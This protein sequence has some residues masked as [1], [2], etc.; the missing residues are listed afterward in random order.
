MWVSNKQKFSKVT[1]RDT[2]TSIACKH[3]LKGHVSVA[4]L[5][6]ASVTGSGVASAQSVEEAAA[7]EGVDQIVVTGIRS[8]IRNALDTKRNAD[9]I[10][11]GISAEDIGK[12]PDQNVAE[13]LQRIP[14]VAIDR[15]GGEGR[16]VSIRGLGPSFAKTLINGREIATENPDRSFSFDTIASELVSAANVYKTQNAY[17]PEGGI[18]GTVDVITA[19]PFDYDGFTIAGSVEGQFEQNRGTVDPEMSFIVSNTFMDDKLGLLASFTRQERSTEFY[20]T[21]TESIVNASAGVFYNFPPFGDATPL[22]PRAVTGPYAYN[23]TCY[24]YTSDGLTDAWRNQDLTRSVT[25]E[26]RVRTGVSAAAQFRPFDDMVITADYIYSDFDVDTTRVG[27]SNW[28]WAVQD[29]E[30]LEI[31]ENGALVF[32]EHGGPFD[33]SGFSHQWQRQ[34]RPTN[35]QMAGIN[36]D[37]DVSDRLTVVLDGAWSSATRDNKGLD[38][39]GTLEILD[40]PGFFVEARGGVP[41]IIG[42]DPGSLASLDN[43]GALRARNNGDS[44][45][46]IDAENWEISG[47]LDYQINDNLQAR[48]G[49]RFVSSEK[50]NESYETPLAV[51]RLYQKFAEDLVIDDIDNI[52]TG[53]LEGGDRFGN[54]ALN[55]DIFLFDNDLLRAWMADPANIAA[56]SGSAEDLQAGLDAFIANGRSWDAQLSGDSFTIT[57]DVTSAYVDFKYDGYLGAMPLD[58]VAGVRYS[59][60]DLTSMG[61]SRILIDLVPESDTTGL[62]ANVFSSDELEEVS[63]DNSYDNWLPSFNGK[64]G[65]TDDLIFRVG[66]SRSLTRP[67]LEALAPSI[68][69]GNFEFEN[70]RTAGASNPML[71]PFVSTNYDVSAEWYYSELGAFAGAFFHKRVK[72]FIVSGIETEIIETVQTPEFQDFQVNRPRNAEEA[73]ITGATFAWTHAFEFGAG[74]QANYTLVNSNATLD[75][76]EQELIFALPGLSDTANV[77]VFYEKGPFGARVAWNWREQFLATINYGGRAGEPRFFDPYYQIDARIS[78]NVSDNIRVSAEAIN[79]TDEKVTS[80]GRFDNLFISRQDFGPRVTFG[81]SARF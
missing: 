12:F 57:E 8:S 51:R 15:Q 43:V 25:R 66:V 58:I 7:D 18:G 52:V 55:S 9:E 47:D 37:W 17:L 60:T 38:Q 27:T 56:R 70:N 68:S 31:D 63:V 20:V 23:C 36:L 72:D 49:A 16:F 3:W 48:F 10:L 44:G 73:T 11:D 79:I 22:N 62:L 42:A 26:H 1:D 32:Y 33:V 41:T 4:A 14:G 13:A 74:F 65:V 80:Q 71:R 29:N 24:F 34:Q 50:I 76:Q 53:I 2:D 81:V 67:T 6:M 64:L 75:L 77:V 39:D 35:T 78:Y 30:N 28:F 19:R 40:Q 21:Q 46:F 69:Y 61:F 59:H 45:L 5:V 54:S